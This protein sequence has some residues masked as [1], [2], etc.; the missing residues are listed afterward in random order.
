MVDS[1]DCLFPIMGARVDLEDLGEFFGGEDCIKGML[2][3][4]LGKDRGL[5]RD[6][7][8]PENLFD[9]DDLVRFLLKVFWRGMEISTRCRH[10]P[11]GQPT[12]Y[13]TRGGGPCRNCL[14]RDGF[15]VYPSGE[16]ACGLVRGLVELDALEACATKTLS[17][18]ACWQ[19]LL[20]IGA[21]P[22]PDLFVVADSHDPSLFFFGYLSAALRAL[23]RRTHL[24]E[25]PT[26]RRD[27]PKAVVDV[28]DAHNNYWSFE[29][30]QRG[31]MGA[32]ISY[33]DPDGLP[34]LLDLPASWDWG[35][36]LNPPCTM[37]EGVHVLSCMK[38]W[39]LLT[40]WGVCYR[41]VLEKEYP[42]RYYG[43]YGRELLDGLVRIEEMGLEGF[44]RYRSEGPGM[45]GDRNVEDYPD[46]P[47]GYSHERR[48]KLYE[49]LGVLEYVDDGWACSEEG[50]DF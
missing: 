36:W 25:L 5:N 49:E 16:G 8:L 28:M 10:Y 21:P 9:L 3:H 33:I 46:L 20:K 26:V 19:A 29:M 23:I 17:S 39:N 7:D 42:L 50:G 6:I 13:G 37:T 38:E 40:R 27:A 31:G 32:R 48:S 43:A 45:V 4:M 2:G 22:H 15:M 1:M 14:V 30:M 44:C 47:V 12:S 24:H 18:V 11:V 35:T 34:P 41:P